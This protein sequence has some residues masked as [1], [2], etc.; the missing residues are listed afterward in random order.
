MPNYRLVER[1]EDGTERE[2]STFSADLGSG[3]EVGRSIQ[4]NG[5][6]WTIVEVRR[7]DPVTLVVTRD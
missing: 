4:R 1:L 5:V 3:I 2:D 7:G 6:D